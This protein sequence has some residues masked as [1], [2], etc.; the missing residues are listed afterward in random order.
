ML[1]RF[2][3]RGRHGAAVLWAVSFI[4]LSIMLAGC[5]PPTG[6]GEG[7]GEGSAE[8]EGEIVIPPPTTLA[9][10]L[11]VEVLGVTIPEDLKP[12]VVLSFK[13][14]SGHLIAQSELTDCRVILDYLDDAVD[15]DT[16][17]Y[18][19]Y[20]TRFDD[21]DKVPNSGDEAVQADYD[22]ARLTGLSYNGDNTFTYKFAKT[23]AADYDPARSHMLAMQVQR[24]FVVD[25]LIYKTNVEYPFIP[26]GGNAA[27]ARREIVSTEACN[28]CHTR[29]SVHGDIRRDVQL[30]IQ[31]HTP[32]TTDAQ[33]GNSLNFAELIHKL[34]RG[35][36]LPSVQGGTPYEIIG[37]NNSV[38]DYSEVEFPQ[39]IRNCQV[40]HTG[41]AQADLHKTNPT[42]AGCASC[43]DRTWFGNPDQT[44]EGWENHVGGQQVNNSL[45]QLCHKPNG[46]APAPIAESHIIPN[47]SEEAPGLTYHIISV[48]PVVAEDGTTATLTVTF[49]ALD[50]D[51][52]R[53]A[54]LSSFG[55]ASM[56]V[57]Y[58]V[59]DYQTVVRESLIGNAIPGTMVH[60]AD[61]THTYT[62]K[63]SF[64]VTGDTFAVGL[65]GRVNYVFR[66]ANY[67]QGPTTSGRTIFTLD[68]SDPQE[69]RQV[70]AMEKCNVCH[71]DLHLHGQ[72]RVG[73]EYCVMC[74]NPNGSDV[75]RRPAGAGDPETIDFKVLIHKIHTGENLTQPY[76]V[77][78]FGGS[79][80]DF[81]GILFPGQTR[82][83]SICHVDGAVD[84]PLAPEVLDTVVKNS[85]GDVVSAKGPTRA[86]CTSCHDD[87]LVDTHA[88]LMTDSMGAESCAVC[89][90]PDEIISA[91]KYHALLP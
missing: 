63:A 90:G 12:E 4:F 5:P 33:S 83:C 46:P 10:G 84:L 42:L 51:G 80:N 15:G 14:G 47:E 75:S 36:E 34:H 49:E 53:Y 6:E 81:T 40:C 55:S 88:V 20:T 72:N 59:S 28:G 31:C 48:D 76:T 86:V 73:V 85:A 27:P 8:G 78:G 62:F 91:N 68:G 70:V 11:K 32:Q 64:P 43:H 52:V 82:Q 87:P 74:H 38:N 67:Q 23:I 45:C 39:D 79:V 58:P 19:S 35:A 22:S 89:H 26:A 71:K 2:L 16:A 18:V 54:S 7:E 17:H 13:D 69:R 24:R 61:G 56:T 30:C 50:K 29:L 3:S 9:P 1:A 37:F 57:A 66:E 65:E 21:P 44:P 77:Y 60:N 25:G 41:A